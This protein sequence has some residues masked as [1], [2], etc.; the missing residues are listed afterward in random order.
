M[1]VN[2]RPC[3]C[4]AMSQVGWRLMVAS[5]AKMSRPRPDATVGAVARPS[6]R[7]A[8]IAADVDNPGVMAPR[9]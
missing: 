8:S 4:I 9:C 2:I 3:S 7:K 5:M 1:S 6:F